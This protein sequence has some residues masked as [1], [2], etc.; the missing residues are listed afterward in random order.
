LEITEN[1]KGIDRKCGFVREAGSIFGSG[2]QKLKLSFV[3]TE[4]PSTYDYG[5]WLEV[6]G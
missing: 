5:F 4:L 2:S 3:T 6:L 1:D